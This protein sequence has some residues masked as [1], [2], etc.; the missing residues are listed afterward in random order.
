MAS[1]ASPSSPL[2][3][4]PMSSGGG[5]EPGRVTSSKVV[6]GGRAT[7]GGASGGGAPD[8]A[9]GP[10]L[11]TSS[12]SGAPLTVVSGASGTPCARAGI[13]TITAT[14]TTVAQT[15]ISFFILLSFS[16]DYLEL[17]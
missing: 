13:A 6:S 17:G 10:L 5:G 14:A 1:F 2:F 15:V 11:C 3:C 4:S 7:G 16:W 8:G 9:S 12:P